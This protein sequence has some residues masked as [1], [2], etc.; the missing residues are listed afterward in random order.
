LSF[1]KR[2]NDHDLN[3]DTCAKKEQKCKCHGNNDGHFYV[4]VLF[5]LDV[6]EHYGLYLGESEIE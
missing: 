6:L 5:R 1:Y 2:L 3:I 4:F